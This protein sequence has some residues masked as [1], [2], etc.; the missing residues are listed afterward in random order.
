MTLIH[1]NSLK[2][3]SHKISVY[4]CHRWLKKHAVILFLALPLH[5][6]A[7]QDTIL[8]NNNDLLTGHIQGM[9]ANFVILEI[10][11]PTGQATRRISPENIKSITLTDTPD[12]EE[13]PTIQLLKSLANRRA[14]LLGILQKQDEQILINL[15]DLYI[16]SNQALEALSYAKLW[17]PKIHYTEHL[18]RIEEQLILAATAANLPDEALVH[19][20]NLIQNNHSTNT[21]LAYHTIANAQLA[22]GN[23]ESALWTALNPIAHRQIS[24]QPYLEKCYATAIA[25]CIDLNNTPYALALKSEMQTYNFTLPPHIQ[26]PDTPVSNSTPPSLLAKNL[27]FESLLKTTPNSP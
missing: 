19:A 27:T 6:H 10:Q 26:I 21:A 7:A 8:L 12:S 18:T 14:T 17:H 25:A 3:I 13:I 5:V 15:L 1:P 9:Q 24:S 23:P 16:E 2:P 11:A 22:K 4:Q 20:H